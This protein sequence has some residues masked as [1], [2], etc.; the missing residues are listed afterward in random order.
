MSQA[1][2]SQT[3]AGTAV[4][5]GNRSGYDVD[6]SSLL[7][8]NT[9]NLTYTDTATNTQ[10]TV[11]IVR[12]NDPSVL[13]LANTSSDPNNKVIGIDF[14]GGVASVA[15]Q[16][17]SAL[18]ST[19][20]QF[21]NPSGTT[22]RVLDDGTSNKIDVN[23]LSATATV[24]SLTNGGVE[25]PLFTDGTSPFSAAIT[26]AGNQSLGYASRITVNPALLADPSKLVAYQSTTAA[27]DTTR[28]SFL[29]DQL[30]SAALSY[31]PQAGIGT[32]AAPFSGS[33]GSYIGRMMSQ[34][35]DAATAA[36]N[37]KQG[38]DVVVST[39]QQRFNDSSSVNIDE[40][41]SKLLN[42]QTAYGANA[43]VMTTINSMLDDLMKVLG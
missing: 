38:Q 36:A 25:M 10:R 42:L 31:S 11:T 16:L 27:G 6:V 40:E 2:S 20:L 4:T 18:G 7:S 19:G 5:S 34:Q 35:G 41:M 1:L 23:S 21:S 24:T 12:V 17:N 28:P 29:L 37:L 33:L 39:L 30:T 3:T 9:V 43:R 14:S 13:P 32:A 8:G 26:A 15:A 22:L